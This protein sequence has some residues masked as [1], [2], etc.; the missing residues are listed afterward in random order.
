L[1]LWAA[2]FVV[3]AVVLLVLVLLGGDDQDLPESIL[4]L[5]AAADGSAVTA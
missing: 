1:L 3:G 2:L 4:G 5:A